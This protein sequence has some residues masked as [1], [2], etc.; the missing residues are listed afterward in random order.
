MKCGLLPVS[1]EY[2]L[3][4]MMDGISYHDFQGVLVDEA[5][6]ESIVKDLGSNKVFKERSCLQLFI[7][8]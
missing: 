5:E 3:I 6:R 2:L 1:Q 7:S 4:T 8:V